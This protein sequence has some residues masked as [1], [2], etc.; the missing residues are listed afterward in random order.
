MSR[1]VLLPASWSAA[2]AAAAVTPEPVLPELTS[3]LEAVSFISSIFIWA[4][5]T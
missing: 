1:L 4:T 2:I 5:V 3:R